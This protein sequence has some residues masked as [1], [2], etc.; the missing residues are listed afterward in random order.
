MDKIKDYLYKDN[1][2]M[3]KNYLDVGLGY[4][5]DDTKK[6]EIKN[7]YSKVYRFVNKEFERNNKLR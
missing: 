1:K 3:L 7:D 4:C 2:D 5:Y 6:K